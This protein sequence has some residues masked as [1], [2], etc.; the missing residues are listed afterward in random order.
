[1]ETY[2]IRIYQRDK[3]DP[4]KVAGI[5]EG[6]G[7]GEKKGFLGPD[8]LWRILTA[9]WHESGRKEET[10][11]GKRRSKDVLTLTEIMKQIAKKQK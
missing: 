10:S 7:K 9:S 8:S 11:R 1:M 6:V 5:V 4:K 2:I 3:K